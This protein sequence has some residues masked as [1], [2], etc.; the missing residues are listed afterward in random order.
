MKAELTFVLENAG[1]PALLVSDSGV[2]LRANSSATTMFGPLSGGNTSLAASIWSRENPSSPEVFLAGIERSSAI[3]TALKLRTK[4]GATSIFHAS[5]CPSSTDGQKMFLMQLFTANAAA[6]SSSGSLS[7]G[8]ASPV[9][10]KTKADDPALDAGLAQK[11]KLDCALQLT[12]TVA[13]DFNNAL[14]SILGHTSLILSKIESGNPWRGSLMEIEKSA[15]KA[16]EIAA[17]LA[18]FSRQEKDSTAQTAGNLNDLV[19]R[20][21]SLFQTPGNEDIIWGMQ[22]ETKLFAAVFEEAKLQQAFMKLLE[23]A[24]QA[25]ENSRQIIVRTRNHDFREAQQDG[26]VR[27][28]PGSYVCVEVE[29]SGCGIPANV[30]PRIFEPFF[31]TKDRTKHRGLGLAWVYGIITNHGGSVAVTSEPGLGTGV[32]VYLPAL[33]RIVRDHGADTDDLTGNE[34]ILMIDDEDLL[35]TMGETILSAYGYRVLTANSGPK[36][37]ELFS[38]A[39]EEI[40][41]VITDLVMPQMAGRE[42]IER[43]RQVAP[44]VRVICTSGYVR[45]VSAEEEET[46]LQKPFTS[47][48]LLRKVKQVLSPAPAR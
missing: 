35:L 5:I 42:V 23:N 29:D 24:V 40:D 26:N 48:D 21:V 12:R 7:G 2:V 28:A 39:P 32:R 30:L 41:L 15:E 18:A 9:P 44:N 13:L 36:A 17:D 22:L 34:T 38:R 25:L 31:T 33:K 47:Q 8:P 14:T 6:A 20:V 43:L 27:L 45:A 11:Q 37:L 46:Y 10:A 16:A 3:S 1:W 19:R 4:D